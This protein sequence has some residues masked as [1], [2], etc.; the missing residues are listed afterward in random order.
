MAEV[1]AA[2]LVPE[3]PVKFSVIR[4]PFFLEADYPVSEDF[5]ETNRKRLIRKW[6]GAREF[7]AQKSRHQLKERG[8]EVGIKHFNLDR[9]AS[10][11]FLSHRLVQWATKEHGITTAENL[12]SILNRRHFE[13]GQKLNDPKMLRKAAE[14]A[15]IDGELAAAFMSSNAGSAEI[16]K[17][18][19]LL[20]DMGVHSIPTF[21]VQGQYLMNGAM[22]SKEMAEMFR[23]LERR[24][25][26]GEPVFAK[27]LGISEDV[28]KQGLQ[29]HR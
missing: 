16:R 27:T 22:A 23:D 3:R 6:G 12:Y 10:S 26:E 28:I 13:E 24:G 17:A 14:E 8:Q 2:P 1:S 21:I 25:E 15:G 11:T 7:E 4:V 20:R 9:I 29:L 19:K 5:Q 18:Q